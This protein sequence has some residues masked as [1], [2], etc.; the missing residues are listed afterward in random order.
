MFYPKGA[1]IQKQIQEAQ[2]E[3]IKQITSRSFCRDVGEIA[4]QETLQEFLERGSPLEK[5][6][7]SQNAGMGCTAAPLHRLAGHS[8]A[9]S[10]RLF[11]PQ[12][13]HIL[14]ALKIKSLCRNCAVFSSAMIMI[15]HNIYIHNILRRYITIYYIFCNFLCNPLPP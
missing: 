8:G 3:T 9:C 15:L 1:L 4:N 13:D 10:Q 2:A 12:P 14:V 5:R 11:D 6:R 7:R